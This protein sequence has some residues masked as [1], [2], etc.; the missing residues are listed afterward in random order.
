MGLSLP[1]SLLPLSLLPSAAAFGISSFEV[2]EIDQLSPVNISRKIPTG[3]LQPSSLPALN[4]PVWAANVS[5]RSL[6]AVKAVGSDPSAHLGD[7]QRLVA[8]GIDV[9]LT[10]QSCSWQDPLPACALK[11]APAEDH[12]RY[13]ARPARDHQHLRPFPDRHR[14]PARGR[15][16]CKQGSERA[17]VV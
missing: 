16:G 11:L 6:D 10:V 17:A 4:L 13:L 7:I 14:H 1:L 3:R 12:N 8:S 15:R 5:Q 9:D 2:Y